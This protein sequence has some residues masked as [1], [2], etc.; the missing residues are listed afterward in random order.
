MHNFPRSPQVAGF[1][2][3]SLAA[4]LVHDDRIGRTGVHHLFR[5]EPDL[6]TM[7]AKR[8]AAG[9]PQLFGSMPKSA[10]ELLGMLGHIALEEIDSPPGPV[11]VG[12]R[13]GASTGGGIQQMAAHYQAA[14]RGRTQIFPYFAAT[15]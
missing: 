3:T 9:G 6:E 15:R 1:T 8:V 7:L 10:Q 13:G 4:K 12:H 5:L 14:F 2:A 11:Q